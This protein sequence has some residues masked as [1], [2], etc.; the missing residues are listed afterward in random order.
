MCALYCLQAVVRPW[1]GRPALVLLASA[2]FGNTG[3][4]VQNPLAVTTS[5][6]C[7]SGSAF[8]PLTAAFIIKGDNAGAVPLLSAG[9]AMAAAAVV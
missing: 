9:F 2:G 8:G 7:P 1:R 3:C 4:A 5:T 6:R